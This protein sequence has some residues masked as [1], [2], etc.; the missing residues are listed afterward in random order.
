MKWTRLFRRKKSVLPRLATVLAGLG[1]L[2]A[3]GLFARSRLRRGTLPLRSAVTINRTPHDVYAL[4]RRD[5]LDPLSGSHELTVDRP[6]LRLEWE[7]GRVMFDCAP[8][9][10]DATELRVELDARGGM[11]ARHELSEH[12]KMIKQMAETGE[13]LK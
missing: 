2:T 3:L 1:G 4:V 9:R 10:T 7:G 5:H 11:L 13:V 12:L 8:G 6:A